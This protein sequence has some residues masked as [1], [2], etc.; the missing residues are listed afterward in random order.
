MA[1]LLPLPPQPYNKNPTEPISAKNNTAQRR[2]R[3][4]V[5]SPGLILLPAT[6][7]AGLWA[8]CNNPFGAVAKAAI[9]DHSAILG[10]SFHFKR[11]CGKQLHAI[12]RRT[13]WQFNF[14]V[15]DKSIVPYRQCCACRGWPG[16]GLL[17][18]SIVDTA[19][20]SEP[21]AFAADAVRLWGLNRFSP[22][23][24]RRIKLYKRKAKSDSGCRGSP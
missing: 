12:V 2:C 4:I 8:T 1:L 22:A 5:W 20:C 16:A 19:I 23:I 24:C 10:L 9:P 21:L 15:V 3:P 7:K 13:A 11:A 14:L 6:F 18:R 17:V